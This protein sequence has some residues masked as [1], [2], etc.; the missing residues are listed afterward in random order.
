MSSKQMHKRIL[1][2]YSLKGGKSKSK[3][4]Y[5]TTARSF[6]FE[7][8]NYLTEV[9]NWPLSALISVLREEKKPHR[10]PSLVPV[11]IL[12]STCLSQCSL[13]FCDFSLVGVSHSWYKNPASFEKAKNE[14]RGWEKEKEK[15]EECVW[16]AQVCCSWQTVWEP[17]SHC[18]P[19]AC[20]N[21]TANREAKKRQT[22]ETCTLTFLNQIWQSGGQPTAYHLQSLLIHNQK[23]SKWGRNWERLRE[24]GGGGMRE[25]ER[26]GERCRSLHLFL[27]AQWEQC[28]INQRPLGCIYLPLQGLRSLAP[29]LDTNPDRILLCPDP[30]TEDGARLRIRA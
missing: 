13:I 12:F 17:W 15:T 14:K 23:P 3:S 29:S 21:V 19:R 22:W 5:R 10:S 27:L 4:Y 9:G 8:Y 26:E 2:V 18:V 24:L 11:L 30:I 16:L 20:V 28:R 1:Y 6:H 7:D 25:K